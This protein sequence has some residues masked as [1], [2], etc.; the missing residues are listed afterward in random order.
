MT[1]SDG[2]G[3]RAFL[4]DKDGS[5]RQVDLDESTVADLSEEHL[6]WVDVSTD[7]SQL[8][9]AGEDALRRLAGE[10]ASAWLGRD[11]GA[12]VAETAEDRLMVGVVGA[13]DHE[14][15]IGIRCLVGPRWI[16]TA[17]SSSVDLI[18]AFNQSVSKGSNLGKMDGPRFLAVLLDGH[19]RSFFD[20]VEEL[21]RK[22]DDL[23]EELISAPAAADRALLDRIV[24]LR[25][26]TGQLRRIVVAHR[27]VLA[28]L[29]DPELAVL[30]GSDSAHR[31]ADLDR[32]LAR[33]L[34]DQ[35]CAAH[36]R[37]N[38][39]AHPRLGTH[40]ALHRHRRGDGHELRGWPV[41]QSGRVL[42]C[43]HRDDHGRSH[44][45]R[46]G[47]APPVDRREEP[48]IVAHVGRA[49]RTHQAFAAAAYPDWPASRRK[50]SCE[51]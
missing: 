33:R 35:D 28:R 3:L 27:D 18:E 7:E 23:D 34:H 36:Q 10:R 43:H 11:D 47:P 45:A 37:G 29:S 19:L 13:T 50:P 44:H 9:G 14:E 32:R 24:Q 30:S 42:D 17:H 4:Y 25:H 26:R 12:A 38:E 51:I 20:R 6:L 8:T 21:D 39:G 49:R 48:V 15:R 40:A 22:V 41:R 46:G 16:V 5:D 2:G 31:F 1:G